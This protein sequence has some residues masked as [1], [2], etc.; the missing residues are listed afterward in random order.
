MTLPGIRI[1][2]T[3]ESARNDNY[4]GR[5]I[6][7]I[8][9]A[10]YTT[11]KEAEKIYT[12]YNYEH[13]NTELNPP[14]DVKLTGKNI[15]KAV[16]RNIFNEGK[17]LDS[18]DTMGLNKVYAIN[19]GPKP[20]IETLIT[21]L[22]TSE[23][24]YDADIE[25]YPELNDIPAMN[26]INGHL[27]KLEGFGDYRIAMFAVSKN[28]SIDEMTGMTDPSSEGAYISSGR[29][30]LHANPDL[31][32]A[33]AAKVAYTP[34]HQ[35]P[36]YKP[37]RTIT[38]TDIKRYRREELET[39]L[40]A[41]LIVDW[42]VVDPTLK[43]K[44]VEPVYARATNYTEEETPGDAYL[45]Q[46]LNADYQAHVTDEIARAYIKR[47]N[48]ETA[49]Q[50]IEQSCKSHLEEEVKQERLDGYSYELYPNRVDPYGLIVQMKVLPVKSI[51][52]IEIN[53]TIQ[54]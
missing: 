27:K 26:L 15:L 14:K 45:H 33:F 1:K 20:T 49:R 44:V 11:E 29:V 37:Y 4:E 38:T 30:V 12:L 35:D 3:V 13:A 21:A 36:A 2:E 48:T 53:R 24:I 34:Y 46:R 19:I 22:E 39:I 52:V 50:A 10:G 7:V 23:T 25:V 9:N 6:L 42:E 47:N 31:L 16:I 54:V 41:G 43:I 18:T 40:D 8:G 51:H 32:G 28:A 5:N 17:P